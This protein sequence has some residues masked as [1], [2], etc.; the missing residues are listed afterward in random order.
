[1]HVDILMISI[2]NLAQLDGE[3][4]RWVAWLPRLTGRK[5]ISYLWYIEW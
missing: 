1:V 5:H 4:A 3:T 2:S